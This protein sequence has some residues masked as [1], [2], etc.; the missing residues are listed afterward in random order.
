M[1]DQGEVILY[2]R[3]WL[4]LRPTIRNA[5]YITHLPIKI[6]QHCPKS[7][8]FVERLLSDDDAMLSSSFIGG[9]VKL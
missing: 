7:G 5:G 6:R 8:D 9:I 1:R 3:N 2:S 4:S